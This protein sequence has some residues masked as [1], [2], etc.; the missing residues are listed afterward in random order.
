[1]GTSF[2]RDQQSQ[3]D[4][5]TDR[6]YTAR[7]LPNT[8]SVIET[9]VVCGLTCPS[10]ED[11]CCGAER[12]RADQGYFILKGRHDD[13]ANILDGHV[14]YSWKGTICIHEVES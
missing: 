1:M 2:C 7:K 14:L 9:K 3:Q 11:I 4:L 13:S 6:T 8:I 10:K 5:T 12:D